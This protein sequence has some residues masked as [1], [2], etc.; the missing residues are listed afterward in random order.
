MTEKT[1]YK[2][3]PLLAHFDL[4][5]LAIIAQFQEHLGV[6]PKSRSDLVFRA[7]EM[8]SDIILADPRMKH[9]QVP[10]YE[11]AIQILTTY[12]IVWQDSS[13]GAS[14]IQHNLNLDSLLDE[15]EAAEDKYLNVLRKTFGSSN[16]DQT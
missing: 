2:R 8:L 1:E 11:E 16:E 6:P 4:R 15:K 14:Q 9:I 10:T 7:A 12:G 13:T 3:V 5:Q